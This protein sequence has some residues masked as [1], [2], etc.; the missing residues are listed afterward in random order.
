[1]GVVNERKVVMPR[2]N[3]RSICRY[4]SSDA[5]G[6]N[7]LIGA[8]RDGIPMEAAPTHISKHAFYK[9]EHDPIN[10]FHGNPSMFF[11]VYKG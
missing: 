4:S 11:A 9:L 10:H 3:H 5:I 6:L 1:M 8:I 7:H 2:C